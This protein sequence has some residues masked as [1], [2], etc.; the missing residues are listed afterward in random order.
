MLADLLTLVAILAFWA[1]LAH[2][3]ARWLTDFRGRF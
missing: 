2:Y 3:I 1:V